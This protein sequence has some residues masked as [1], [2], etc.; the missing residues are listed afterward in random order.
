MNTFFK[1]LEE[2]RILVGDGAMGTTLFESGLN[3]GD[4]PEYLNITKP[5]IVQRIALGYIAAGSDLIQT[6]SFGAS[7]LKLAEYGLQDKTENINREAV[8]LIKSIN[9]DIL[10]SGSI[11]P[12]G[13]IMAPLGDVDPEEIF[14]GFLLQSYALIDGGVDV[15]CIE[16]MSDIH[17]LALAVKAVKAHS[18]HI[19]IIATMTFDETPHGFFTVM[20]NSIPDVVSTLENI[21]VDILGSNCG[22]GLQKMIEIANQ[23]IS[24]STHPIIIQSN[25]GL[26]ELINNN[27]RFPETPDFFQKHIPELLISGVSIIGGCCGTTPEYIRRIRTVVDNFIELKYS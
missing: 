3:I 24:A 12:T 19:P 15:I 13:K 4:C 16:T 6:N 22:N 26:P 20:G 9:K 21:G 23:F 17:E 8:R 25:A 7:P 1:V 18:S 27:L 5:D 11:G 10:I 14:D 2:K